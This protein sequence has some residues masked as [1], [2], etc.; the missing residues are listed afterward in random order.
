MRDTVHLIYYETIDSPL[1]I[2]LVNQT[3][4]ARGFND[5]FWGKIYEFV[6]ELL[7]FIVEFS[8]SPFLFLRLSRTR[9]T[10]RGDP[11]SLNKAQIIFDKTEQRHDNKGHTLIGNRT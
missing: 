2:K 5:A 4:Q 3:H 10:A 7:D 1:L 6:F 9:K 11:Q 8:D